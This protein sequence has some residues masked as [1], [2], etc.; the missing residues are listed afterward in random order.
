MQ[1]IAAELNSDGRLVNRSGRGARRQLRRRRQQVQGRENTP[2]TANED[3]NSVPAVNP[4]SQNRAIGSAWA[5]PGRSPVSR[6][7]MSHSRS[8]SPTKLK[9]VQSLAP[10]SCHMV[11]PARK[12][13]LTGP[14]LAIA[15]RLESSTPLNS[16]KSDESS[17]WLRQRRELRHQFS[18]SEH[19]A[20]GKKMA[21]IKSVV[22]AVCAFNTA[23]GSGITFL[24][25][26]DLI[27]GI[28]GVISSLLG[29]YR[30]WVKVMPWEPT[31]PKP[32]SHTSWL[33]LGPRLSHNFSD[34][35]ILLAQP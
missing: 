5:S 7:R 23:R 8:M 35:D 14:A 18:V 20:F 21:F 24:H 17:T 13:K 2:K 19:K 3:S 25:Y 11:S 26:T 10:P 22:D 32:R 12:S 30:A 9:L 4:L 34:E 27:I 31:M 15:S 6:P 28:M 16:K 1:S 29:T 33:H